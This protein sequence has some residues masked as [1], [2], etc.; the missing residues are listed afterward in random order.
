MGKQMREDRT[1]E[2]QLENHDKIPR[3]RWQSWWGWGGQVEL[4]KVGQENKL[5]G[6]TQVSISV[7]IVSL[8]G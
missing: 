6:E 3:K 7:R 2:R 1:G 4:E 5:K 8:P